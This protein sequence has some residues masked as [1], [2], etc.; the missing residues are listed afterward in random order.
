VTRPPLYSVN[1][2]IWYVSRG[3]LRRPIQRLLFKIDG[4]DSLN[5]CSGVVL[6]GRKRGL[7]IF[8]LKRLLKRKNKLKKS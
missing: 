6:V 4:R 5:L 7:V 1:E 3:P 8:E 2:E